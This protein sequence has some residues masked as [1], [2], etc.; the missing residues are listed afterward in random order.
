MARRRRKQLAPQ[1]HPDAEGDYDVTREK[2][3]EDESEQEEGP[4]PAKRARKQKPGTRAKQ[5]RVVVPASQPNE[6]LSFSEVLFSSRGAADD[7]QDLTC[8][9]HILNASED[10][11]P[12]VLVQGKQDGKSS[13]VGP[14]VGQ[15]DAQC[16]MLCAC[17]GWHKR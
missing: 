12:A 5:L 4:R 17:C 10:A 2:D 8:E 11:E 7:E 3:A 15:G 13:D 14:Q 9:L 6:L 1:R 16:P